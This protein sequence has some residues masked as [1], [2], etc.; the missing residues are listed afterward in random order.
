MGAAYVTPAWF[1]PPP[2]SKSKQCC[3]E[4]RKD[5]IEINSYYTAFHVL[6]GQPRW[7]WG[8][9]RAIK[10]DRSVP[11]PRLVQT[12]FIQQMQTMLQGQQGTT[13]KDRIEVNSYYTMKVTSFDVLAGQPRWRWRRLSRLIQALITALLKLHLHLLLGSLCPAS[14]KT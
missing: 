14:S 3:R 4:T 12:S 2:S 9:R 11:L 6:T 5:R 7:R 13:R 10:I 8:R 1:K